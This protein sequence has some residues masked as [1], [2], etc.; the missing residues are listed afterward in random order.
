MADTIVDEIK[1]NMAYYE[2]LTPE[3][4]QKLKEDEEKSLIEFRKWLNDE[5]NEYWKKKTK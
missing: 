4:K 3:E 2:S 1:Q 5:P